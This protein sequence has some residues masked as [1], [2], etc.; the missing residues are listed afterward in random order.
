MLFFAL[1][2][3]KELKDGARGLINCTWS[4]FQTLFWH[5]LRVSSKLLTSQS[6]WAWQSAPQQQ[7]AAPSESSNG[8]VLKRREARR[9][10]AVTELRAKEC[11]SSRKR[12]AEDPRA[13]KEL[14]L[15]LCVSLEEP[16]SLIE[17]G[18]PWKP[19]FRLEQYN[20]ACIDWWGRSC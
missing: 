16:R 1:Q 11:W 17:A 12:Q 6:A 20:W 2:K 10:Q 4:L 13:Q 8:W 3:C 5:F 9:R 19:P 18:E 14:D 7:F 15:P